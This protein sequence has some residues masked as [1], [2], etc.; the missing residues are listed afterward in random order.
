MR[1]AKLVGMKFDEYLPVTPGRCLPSRC[2]LCDK[3][4]GVDSIVTVSIPERGIW[5]GDT[6]HFEHLPEGAQFLHCPI[7]L[8]PISVPG[9]EKEP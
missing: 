3:V 5:M 4:G 8:W 7:R 9:T 1:S 6:Y 2:N